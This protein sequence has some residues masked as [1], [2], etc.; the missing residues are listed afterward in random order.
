MK[1]PYIIFISLFFLNVVCYSQKKVQADFEVKDKSIFIHFQFEGDPEDDYEVA[2]CIKRVPMPEFVYEPLMLTGDLST[3]PFARIKRTFIWE[4]NEE[5][6]KHFD[7][8]DDFYFEVMFIETG[9]WFVKMLGKVEVLGGC[10]MNYCA[11]AEGQDSQENAK[12]LSLP[13]RQ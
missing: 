4:L 10:A 7:Y 11:I 8:S 9:S 12:L 1:L 6:A 13:A 5:E 3:G 2:V